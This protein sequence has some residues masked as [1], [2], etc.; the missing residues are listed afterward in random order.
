MFRPLTD[1]NFYNKQV[2]L[3]C[4]FNVPIQ[5]GK[6]LDDFK[7]QNALF[8]IKFLKKA[9]AKIC[10]LTHLGRPWDI[11]DKKKRQEKFTLKPVYEKLQELLKEDI[12]FISDE[13][14]RGVRRKIKKMNQGDIAMLE[15]LRFYKEE[16]E[17]KEKFAE[18]LSLLG[19]VFVGEH[20]SVCHRKNASIAILPQ[21]LPDRIMGHQLAKE[22]E[23]L[24]RI[25]NHPPK[26]L[27]VVIG[28]AKVDSKIRVGVNLLKS[29]DFLL[30]G[31]K[32]ANTILTVQGIS[33]G[34]PWPKEAV[35]QLARHF[36]LTDTKIYLPVDVIVSSDPEGKDLIRETAPGVVRKDEDIFDIGPETIYTFCEIIKSAG[37][38][39]WAGPLGLYQTE[40]YMKGTKAIGEAIAN[41]NAE[42]K[43]VGGGE[44]VAAVRSLGLEDRFTFISSGGGA[45]LSFLSRE[46]MPGL[47][48]LKTQ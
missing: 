7:I 9:G 48:A 20:F 1:Y 25:F 19:D 3:R 33:I 46:R 43:I 14:G 36:N 37:S 35:V 31:G 45:M 6:V 21:L 28:G 10:I 13:I 12:Y 42:L 22:I 30:F 24:S 34:K 38:V 41:C 39:F 23:M 15:N 47:E 2:L 8:T 11:K 32:I 5:D 44:T 16:Q 40:Q 4:D 26:P 17:N 29:A 18:K 27:V